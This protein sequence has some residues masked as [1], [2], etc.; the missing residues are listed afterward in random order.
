VGAIFRYAAREPM[1]QDSGTQDASTDHSATEQNE[2]GVLLPADRKTPRWRKV[3][4]FLGLVLLIW[5][6]SRLNLGEMSAAISKVT[7]STLLLSAG[8]FSV[9][10]FLKA[11]RWHRMLRAQG[12][13]LPPKVTLA[14]FLSGLF[15][16]QITLGRVGELFRVEALLERGVGTGAALASSILD[17]LLDLFL[18]L[19]AGSVLGAFVIGNVRVAAL[20]FVLMT[21]GGLATWAGIDT[22]GHPNPSPKVTRFFASFAAR[23]FLDRIGKLVRELATGL[24]PMTRPGPLAEALL[25]T[26]IAWGFYFEALFVLADGL[27]ILISQ[28]VLMATAAFAALSALLPVTISGLGARELIYIAVLKQHGVA[29]EPAAVLSLLHLLIMT[30]SAIAFGFMG[31]VLRSRQKL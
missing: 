29:D 18:V 21:L 8:S 25:W 7:M 27:H 2:P 3:L 22:I 13:T 12:I 1:T 4:P 6:L 20:A 16:G 11:F 10:A 31:V 26:V 14:A 30:I 9:N 24:Y 28:I 17:R 5:V 15:Y 23:P 19:L